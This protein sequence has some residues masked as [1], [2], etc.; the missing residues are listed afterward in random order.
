MRLDEGYGS[1]PGREPGGTESIQVSIQRHF[2]ER[3]GVLAEESIE[4]VQAVV[5]EVL[6]LAMGLS[7][8]IDR[9]GATEEFESALAEVAGGSPRK[10]G[11]PAVAW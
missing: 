5:P 11:L 8:H 1:H 6:E 2:S 4:I 9:A 10:T 3:I 7:A